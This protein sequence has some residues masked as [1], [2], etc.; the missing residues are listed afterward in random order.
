[1]LG[2]VRRQPLSQD[3]RW[4]LPGLSKSMQEQDGWAFLVPAALQQ[5]GHIHQVIQTKHLR[6]PELPA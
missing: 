5:L 3:G 6:N 2:H 4:I 1:M